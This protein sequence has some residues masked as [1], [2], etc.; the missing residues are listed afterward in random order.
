MSG[1]KQFILEME[2][3]ILLIKALT[4]FDNYGSEFRNFDSYLDS[5]NCYFCCTFIFASNY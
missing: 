5:D 1:L 2:I 4:C 3:V